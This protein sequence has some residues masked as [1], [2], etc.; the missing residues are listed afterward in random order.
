MNIFEL[1]ILWIYVLLYLSLISRTNSIL[2]RIIL[3]SHIHIKRN[4]WKLMTGYASCKVGIIYSQNVYRIIKYII[5]SKIISNGF[6]LFPSIL[7]GMTY[8]EEFLFIHYN[9]GKLHWFLLCFNLLIFLR[10]IFCHS[11][12]FQ[13]IFST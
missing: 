12:S 13:L 9:Y 2:F 3:I 6:I 11:T 4:L 1:E 8:H 5:S 7:K 10:V